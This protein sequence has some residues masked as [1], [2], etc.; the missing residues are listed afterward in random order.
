[1]NIN[2]IYHLN[3]FMNMKYI[4]AFFIL[5]FIFSFASHAQEKGEITSYLEKT[6]I[7]DLALDGSKIWIST[8]GGGIYEFLIKEERFKRYSTKN[9]KLSNDLIFSIAVA[10]KYVFAGSID[11]LFIY[12]KRRRRWA[13]R[14][15]GKGG[16]L[17]NYIRDIYYDEENDVVW[18]GRFQY[19]TAFYVKKRRFK[20]YDMTING[21]LK[22]NSITAVEKDFSNNLWI[23]TEAG[24]IKIDLSGDITDSEKRMLYDNRLNYFPGA[25]KTVSVS[26][27]LFER[28]YIWIG[29]NEFVTAKNPAYN[30]GGLYRFDGEIEWLRFDK[31][32]GLPANGISALTRVGNFIFAAV[33]QFGQNSKKEFGRGIAIIN[34]ITG[35]IS[36]I[37]S[38]ELSGKINALLFD[39]KNLWAGSDAGLFKI[40]I[41][42]KLLNWS[43]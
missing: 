27:L 4:H 41:T 43:K 30:T 31:K 21:N 12:D 35:K 8:E 22:T 42:N 20:D 29:C 10:K 39:G 23:G 28:N 25:G 6:K 7:T 37:V 24:L 17:G 11:G 40:K 2:Y 5:F 1:M 38:E 14:K 34:R 13:K 18:I 36:V 32:N 3:F 9:N 26:S 15:F 19:L 16:Q 33:Y